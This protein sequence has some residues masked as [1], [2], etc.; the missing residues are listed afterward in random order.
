LDRFNLRASSAKETKEM[1]KKT[2]SQL[3]C[4]HKALAKMD[5][6]AKERCGKR[7]TVIDKSSSLEWRVKICES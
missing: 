5:A 6:L 4:H 3:I 7:F 1:I 2:A